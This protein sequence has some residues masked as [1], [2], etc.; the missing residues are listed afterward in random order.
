MGLA[1]LG[2]V[3]LG[4]APGHENGPKGRLTDWL[5]GW[6]ELVFTLP[7]HFI[8]SS[9]SKSLSEGIGVSACVR[10]CVEYICVHV[11]FYI[12]VWINDCGSF[13]RNTCPHSSMTFHRLLACLTLPLLVPHMGSCSYTG[14]R[15]WFWIEVPV[16]ESNAVIPQ[17]PSCPVFL[18]T[19]QKQMPLLC[20]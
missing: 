14:E 1:A 8:F 2:W 19:A 6:F 20:Y 12:M 11:C 18:N 13:F 4:R 17:P 10:A 3:T 5:H 7:P 15:T 9:V 16:C